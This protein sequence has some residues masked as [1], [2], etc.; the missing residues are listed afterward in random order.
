MVLNPSNDSSL[1]QVALK[2]LT[3]ITSV[4]KD[5]EESC[6][7]VCNLGNAHSEVHNIIQNHGNRCYRKLGVFTNN[8]CNYVYHPTT[9]K[10]C[11]HMLGFRHTT[12]FLITLENVAINDAL[13]LE[14][15]KSNVTAK[16]KSFWG[17]TT[18]ATVLARFP[19]WHQT[20][21]SCKKA[22]CRSID[23]RYAAPR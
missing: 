8:S 20:D 1:E 19:Y 10:N 14:A 2:G 3:I 9:I 16:L 12:Q 13:P 23:V 21:P 22:Q 15:A 6:L 5:T 7:A 17:F 11:F 18:P 4:C